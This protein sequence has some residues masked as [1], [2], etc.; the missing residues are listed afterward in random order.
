MSLYD[1]EEEFQSLLKQAE[2]GD[3]ESQLKLGLF[4]AQ[5][6]RLGFD[7]H[8]I[9][10]IA[11]CIYW[12]HKAAEQGNKKAQRYLHKHYLTGQAVEADEEKAKYW[13]RKFKE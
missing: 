12:F 7:F 2:D 5:G 10:G 9:D 3:T 11:P 13:H 4:Y 6:Y 8:P 1:S